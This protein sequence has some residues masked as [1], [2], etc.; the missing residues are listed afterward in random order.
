MNQIN[1]DILDS[2]SSGEEIKENQFD[3]KSGYP[4]IRNFSDIDKKKTK[5]N[6]QSMLNLQDDN[7]SNHYNN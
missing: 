3:K 6:Y 2:S 4:L 7:L 5:R 1:Q